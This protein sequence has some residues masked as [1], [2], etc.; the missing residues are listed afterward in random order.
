MNNEF[1]HTLQHL[2]Q[3]IG[4]FD[5]GIGGISILNAMLSLSPQEFVYVADTGH[6]P[7]GEKTIE[8]LHN[9]AQK[10]MQYFKDL[11][12]YT[13]VIACHTSSVTSFDF[14]RTTFPEITF[15]DPLSWTI[16]D[17]LETTKNDR[18]GI[19]ATE[20]SIS[21]HVHKNMLHTQNKMLSVV[22]QACPLFVPLLESSAKEK[23][24]VDAVAVYTQPLKNANVDTVILGCTHYPFLQNKIMQFF[25]SVTCISAASSLHKRKK[26]LDQTNSFKHVS[27]IVSGDIPLFSALAK[28]YFIGGATITFQPM[29]VQYC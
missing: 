2:P 7:Y 28:N 25:P 14:L 6:V 21:T 4:L 9:R 1:D 18:V 29:P 23:E 24:L 15:I 11:G 3:K 20:R 8:Y 5:S 16:T 19:L 10:I 12:I 13:V 17:A 26:E 27:F 22:E